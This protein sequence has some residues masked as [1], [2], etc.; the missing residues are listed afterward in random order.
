MLKKSHILVAN[1]TLEV[2]QSKIDWKINKLAYLFG[3][4]APDINYIYP[5]HTMSKTIKRFEKRIMR[6]EGTPR[7]IVKSFT[8]GVITHYICDYFCY[9]HNRRM[10]DPKHAIYERLLKKH[11]K[12]HI[13]EINYYPEE[14]KTQW[15]EILKHTADSMESFESIEDIINDI[16]NSGREHIEY[17]IKAMS[18]MHTHYMNSSDEI[19]NDKWFRSVKKIEIDMEYAR[20]MCERILMLILCPE[21]EFAV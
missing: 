6:V 15:D 12:M 5:V 10:G 20:F 7:N 11:L 16:H 9:A 4:V 2:I 19:D 21:T 1:D 13:E 14:L 8:L 3:S 17:I 18:E